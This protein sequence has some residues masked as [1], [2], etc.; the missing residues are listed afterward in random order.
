MVISA[1]SAEKVAA[2]KPSVWPWIIG[3]GAGLLVLVL[4]LRRR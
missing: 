1:P 4:L 3:G 2:P